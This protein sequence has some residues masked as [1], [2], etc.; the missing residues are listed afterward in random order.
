MVRVNPDAQ[1]VSA[2]NPMAGRYFALFSLTG[3]IEGVLSV[4]IR[5]RGQK[6]YELY[7][8]KAFP[9]ATQALRFLSNMEKT[10]PMFVIRNMFD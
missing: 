7:E 2:A 8:R 9:T 3:E 4:F 5:L 6:H 1:R 10:A